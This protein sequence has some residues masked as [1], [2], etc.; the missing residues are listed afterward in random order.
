MKRILLF[1]MAVVATVTMAAQVDS[2]VVFGSVTNFHMGTPMPACT[3]HLIQGEDTLYS[4][5]SDAEGFFFIKG[6]PT[7]NY[8]LSVER[9]FSLYMANL[10][11]AENA[12]LSISVDTVRHVDLMPVRVTSSK[13]QLDGKLIT[14]PEDPRL[15]DFSG[16]MRESFPAN[17]GGLR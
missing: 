6:V 2:V 5:L 15:W 10:V 4:S 3:I 1:M 11:L 12:E 9:E 7:G 8:T 14:T 16:E 17:I 13:H